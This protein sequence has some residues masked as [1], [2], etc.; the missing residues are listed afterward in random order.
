MSRE[1]SSSASHEQITKYDIYRQF[2]LF[3]YR[4]ETDRYL[5][6]IDYQTL[7]MQKS[8]KY[9]KQREIFGLCSGMEEEGDIPES[10]Y[11]EFF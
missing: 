9:L 6:L 2:L 3:H 10:Y 8:D 7:M 11:L 4:K 1:D 5:D